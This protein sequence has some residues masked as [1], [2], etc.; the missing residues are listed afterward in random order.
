VI[1]D[2]NV[3]KL[4]VRF[5]TPPKEGDAM[6]KVVSFGEDGKCNHIW[7]GSTMSYVQYVI[8]DG[9]TEVECGECGTKLDPM[10][11]LTRMAREETQWGRTR[12]HYIEEM[13]R[14]NE[15]S[16]TKCQHCGQMTRIE[17][18]ANGA[19]AKIPKK[20][21]QLIGAES[22][23]DF[24]LIHINAD[25]GG[26]AARDDGVEIGRKLNGRADFFVD[27]LLDVIGS[28]GHDLHVL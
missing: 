21:L 4:P 10:W 15:R 18:L 19:F 25:S 14:L 28:C 24:A 3:K 5:K 8:R 20:L 17:T 26:I 11:V 16:R 13:R 23:I 2:D 6:L 7:R 1:D 9:E 27:N 22:G 12:L